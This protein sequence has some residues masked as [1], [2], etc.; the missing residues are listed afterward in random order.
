MAEIGGAQ[1]FAA[2]LQLGVT[3]FLMRYFQK[4]VEKAELVHR[5]QR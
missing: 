1:P 3:D 5:L 2:D 4:T